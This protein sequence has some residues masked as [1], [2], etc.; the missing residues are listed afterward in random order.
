MMR[1]LPT[2]DSWARYSEESHR[3]NLRIVPPREGEP[4]VLVH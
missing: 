1:E 4:R 2:V 3:L